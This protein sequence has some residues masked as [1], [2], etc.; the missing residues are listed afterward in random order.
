MSFLKTVA[1]DA[2]SFL[3]KV[4]AN[5]VSEVAADGTVTK[6]DAIQAVASAAVSTL[7]SATSA[8]ST[9]AASGAVVADN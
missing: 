4:L 2:E 5:L 9:A 3:A 7:A 1:V 8:S 6:A